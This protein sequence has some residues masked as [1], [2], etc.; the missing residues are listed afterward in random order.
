MS[1]AEIQQPTPENIAELATQIVELPK[2]ALI[3]IFGSQSAPAA[4]IR[5]RKGKIARVSLGDR[6]AN[7]TVTAIAKDRVILTRGSQTK[8]LS[9][10]KS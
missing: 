6:L 3:G 10:P 1:T 8:A 9:L 7:L 2:L 5:T 4:L